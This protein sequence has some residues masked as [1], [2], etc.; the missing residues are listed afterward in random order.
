M[1]TLSSISSF[2]AYLRLVCD[3]RIIVSLIFVFSN[4]IF[5]TLHAQDCFPDIEP[6]VLICKQDY[7]FRYGSCGNETHHASEFVNYAVDNCS[8]VTLSF[9]REGLIVFPELIQLIYDLMSPS[10]E[11]QIF[12]RDE[13]GNVSTCSSKVILYPPDVS[14]NIK[15]NVLSK[16]DWTEPEDYAKIKIK[17]KT[18]D[19]QIHDIYIHKF[20][21]ELD[22]WASY[23][24]EFKIVSL[25]AEAKNETFSHN[26]ITTKDLVYIQRRIVG[27]NWMQGDI[28]FI[29]GDVDCNEELNILDLYKIFNYMM[30]FQT[31]DSCLAAPLVV[32]SNATKHYLG[33]EIPYVENS[34]NPYQLILNQKGNVFSEIGI[35][36]NIQNKRSTF[37]GP[38]YLWKTDNIYCEANHEY[39][40]EFKFNCLDSIFGFQTNLAFDS[41]K[42]EIHNF[43]SNHSYITSHLISENDLKY[44]WINGIN[45][46]F[47]NEPFK[48]KLRILAKKDVLLRNAFYPSNQ[49]ISNF[50]VDAQG[51]ASPIEIEF[52]KIIAGPKKELEELNLVVKTN[53]WNDDVFLI[54]KINT[55]TTGY[56]KLFN[57]TG[58]LILNKAIFVTDG[59]VNEHIAIQ[60]PGFYILQF[61]SPDGDRKSIRFQK[62]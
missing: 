22:L 53:L 24:P 41:S 50:M 54:G 4:F 15:F 6:P 59:N 36:Q 32:F 7:L 52:S 26:E 9:D 34:T 13:S 11:I 25:I 12:A 47:K 42:I 55:N 51:N 37:L 5:P 8:K 20:G 38:A 30:G 57:L 21:E 62:F 61:E 58:A 60:Q 49:T 33:N 14:K 17:F 2:F 44:S 40:I 16:L 23:R 46:N 56:I 31:Q 48:I 10:G 3:T 45:I 28:N 39:T 29:S 19:Q 27:L 35:D 43:E 1:K 18:S